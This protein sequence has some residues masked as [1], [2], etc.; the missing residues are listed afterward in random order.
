MSA[1]RYAKGQIYTIRSHQT[2]DVYIGSTCSPLHKR[3]TEHKSKYK[4]NNR[5]TSSFEIVKYDDAYIELLE[6]FPCDNKK[7]LNRREGQLIR[8]NAC[9]NKRFSGRTHAEWYQDNKERVGEVSRKWKNENKVRCSEVRRARYNANKD[10]ASAYSMARYEANKESILRQS[11]ERVTCECGVVVCR[12][13]IG[14]H[15]KTEKHALLLEEKCQ[16]IL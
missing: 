10:A 7:E 14:T 11:A 1:N 6:D 4:T 15:K 5:Y 12:A 13:Y 9:V 16:A 2:D 8:Q 3:L